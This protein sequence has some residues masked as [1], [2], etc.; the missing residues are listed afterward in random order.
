MTAFL[1]TLVFP[2]AAVCILPV[3]WG[4]D[5]VWYSIILAEVLAVLVTVL[6]LLGKRKTYHY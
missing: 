1:R 6:F 4:L 3:F 2:I 5:G